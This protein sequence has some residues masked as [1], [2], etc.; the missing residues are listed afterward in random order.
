[1]A[2]LAKL[3]GLQSPPHK[4][5]ERV[6]EERARLA[7]MALPGFAGAW[8]ALAQWPG[9]RE[10]AHRLAAPTL[11]IYGELDV[12]VR[13]GSQW[14]ATAIPGARLESIPEAGHSPQDERPELFNAV[15]AQHLRQH[16]RV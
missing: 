12:A 8:Y 16:A 15:L 3:S 11:V 13:E 4:R 1:M 7:R 10:R 5:Q 14:L 6:A 9:T 2:A